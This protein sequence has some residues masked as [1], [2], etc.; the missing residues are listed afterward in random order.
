MEAAF[1]DEQFGYFQLPSYQS[2]AEYRAANQ[3]DLASRQQLAC[4]DILKAVDFLHRQHIL[5]RD[6]RL[7]NVFVAND[8]SAVLGDF[9][10]AIN[11]LESPCSARLTCLVPARSPPEV[12]SGGP[13]EA[14]SEMFSYGLLVFEINFAQLPPNSSLPSLPEEVFLLLTNRRAS[15]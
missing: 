2:W 3:T 12:A 6:L 13:Y 5:H 8:G 10:K 7:G 9:G 4:R 14:A 15:T 11:T 1:Q